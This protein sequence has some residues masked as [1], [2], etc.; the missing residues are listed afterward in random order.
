LKKYLHIK[1]DK[2]LISYRKRLHDEG[3]EIIAIDF[4][5]EYNLHEYGEK[6]CLI[7]IYDGKRFIIID[8]FCVSADELKK[9]LENHKITKIFYD[10]GTDKI[11]V[12][13]QYG[14]KI[15]SILDLMDLVKLLELQKK[16]LDSV[17]GSMMNIIVTKKQKFQRHNWT[18]RPIKDDAI[19]YALSDVEH[20]FSLKNILLKKVIDE[21]LY[22]RLLLGEI[23]NNREFKYSSIPG[24][25]KKKPYKL[26]SP[27]MRD[28]FDQIFN[29]RDKYAK[30]MNL[31]PNSVI[32]NDDLFN[33][34]K[35]I[36]RFD[37]S[38]IHSKIPG[39]IKSE[40]LSS[41][42]EI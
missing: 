28:K 32:S 10:A 6:L 19:Q 25:K 9:L 40:I 24:I 3:I 39:N 16:G 42:E 34:A 4:E 23:K 17:L 41:L 15:N 12:Y 21:G 18:I 36:K 14:I 33:L 26:L 27:R 37:R 35:N 1:S 13:K 31:P 11:L 22:E 5:A 38:V 30:K 20:L 8:P 7:Q 2:D 29:V